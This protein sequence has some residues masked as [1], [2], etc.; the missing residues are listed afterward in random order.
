MLQFGVRYPMISTEDSADQTLTWVVMNI[1]EQNNDL[2]SSQPGPQ[3]AV[4][5][6]QLRV[7]KEEIEKFLGTY[8]PQD[9]IS[10]FHTLPRPARMPSDQVPNH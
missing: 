7:A 4:I 10:N 5:G 3:G 2:A 1:L 6:L 9:L 8:R